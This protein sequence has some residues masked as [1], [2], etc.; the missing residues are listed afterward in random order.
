LFVTTTTSTSSIWVRRAPYSQ[1]TILDLYQLTRHHLHNLTLF[2]PNKDYHNL[3]PIQLFPIRVPITLTIATAQHLSCPPHYT[4][5]TNNRRP[6]LPEV[7]Q[8]RQSSPRNQIIH[9]NQRNTRIP[10]R[11]P[12]AVPRADGKLS[13]S[14]HT[15]SSSPFPPQVHSSTGLEE[16]KKLTPGVS[17]YLTP[18]P[19][20]FATLICVFKS[21][22]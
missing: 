10:Q 19:F 5:T 21:A 9:I 2:E 14:Q 3:E 22:I 13:T 6:H 12:D 15:C 16:G 11:S 4:L 20:P 8:I 18:I 1:M 17:Q 7:A